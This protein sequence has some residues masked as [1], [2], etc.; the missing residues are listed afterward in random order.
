[1][2]SR[3]PQQL[4]VHQHL[5][6]LPSEVVTLPS[7][8]FLSLT[9]AD[10]II[11]LLEEGGGGGERISVGSGIYLTFVLFY[12]CFVLVLSTAYL[13]C[14]RLFCI[15]VLANSRQLFS[16]FSYDKLVLALLVI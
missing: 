12:T 6:H 7:L 2:C 3:L 9:R 1:M 8:A 15:Y 4:Q 16:M 11:F 13:S 14:I 5:H 10:T